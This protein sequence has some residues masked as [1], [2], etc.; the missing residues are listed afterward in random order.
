MPR[1]S[2]PRAAA[3]AAPVVLAL[4]AAA[5]SPAAAAASSASCA[6]D[7][8]YSLRV[9]V[10]Q[11]T[12]VH[13]TYGATD[14][15]PY[16]KEEIQV[17]GYRVRVVNHDRRAVSGIRV[18]VR[19]TVLGN[20]LAGCDGGR[21]LNETVD[22]DLGSFAR[23]RVGV[24]RVPWRGLLTEVTRDGKGVQA[25]NAEVR[26]RYRGRSQTFQTKNVC[27]GVLKLSPAVP[28]AECN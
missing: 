19:A 6:N 1:R 26:F 17:S 9:C 23:K 24:L 28:F 14:D 27:A 20:C 2:R 11:L 7:G 4:L 8:S 10:W 21:Y 5:P 3:L 13:R 15:H 18:R 22:K 12:S 25:G 16:G